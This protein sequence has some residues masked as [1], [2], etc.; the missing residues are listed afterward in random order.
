VNT[1]P[2]TAPP[3]SLSP[4]Q[5]LYT[6]AHGW[7]R[8]WYRRRAAHLP[9]PVLSVGNLHWG[10][11]G[12]TP[13]VTAI[14]RH[15]DELGL[16]V[17]ILSRGYKSR[18][19]GIR[20]VSVGDGPLLGPL[21][22]GDEPVVLAAD[23]PGV[24]VVVGPDRYEAGQHALERLPRRPDIFILEDG[25]SHLRLYRDVN[26]LTFPIRDPF[27]G[28]RLFPGGRLREPLS[29][30]RDADAA[31]LVGPHAKGGED[32][33]QCLRPFGFRGAGFSARTI[34]GE[35][36]IER[37][38]LLAAGSRV[39]LVTGIARPERVLESLAS[40]PYELAGALHFSDHHEYPEESLEQI[41]REL[42][43]NAA[44]WVLT[45]AKDHVKLLGRLEM[46]IALLP[47]RTEPEL[48][49]WHWLEQRLGNLA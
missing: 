23:L 18:G 8:A 25:F 27:G 34:V 33:A 15:I 12:K 35:A 1:S 20:I 11:T 42:D 44:D 41:R 2:L 38:E 48:A 24:S 16:H 17:T 28:G 3:P 14:A 9:R 31:V 40:L 10:G 26:V 4:W 45:T 22:A 37:G 46:P 36:R 6:A 19:R 43:R 7:R 30:S 21:V 49:F 32:L 29:S 47:L 5:R 39:L 13:L